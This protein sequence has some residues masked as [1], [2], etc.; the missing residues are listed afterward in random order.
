MI[1]KPT[2]IITSLGRT[3][4]LFFAT[5]FRQ[6]LPDSTSLHEPDYFN[7]GQYR[8]LREKTTEAIRQIRE[9]GFCN[10][11]IRKALGRWNL[12]AVSDARVC[13]R[14]TRSDAVDRIL[15]QRETFAS[16][17]RGSIYVE[18]SSALYGLID[19]LPDVF[20]EHRVIYLVR[21]GRDWIRSMMNFTAAVMYGKTRL[22]S[23]VSPDWPTAAE[24][25]DGRFAAKWSSMSV[26]EKL[27]WAWTRLN[28]YALD[29]VCENPHARVFRFEDVF[30]GD[31]RYDYLQELV[32]FA[33]SFPDVRLSRQGFNTCL[34][35]EVHGSSTGFPRWEDW[36]IDQ[37]R[38]YRATCGALMERL[39]YKLK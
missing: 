18:S 23:L 38:Q 36:S 27:C 11:T 12:R 6:L 20:S 5:L 30:K 39:G 3:G 35:Q 33:T 15:A 32:T 7:F 21:D 37:K 1:E 14:L 17:R 28:G 19:V 8:S 26:F 2:V 25:K 13:G 29:S 9:S 34:E 22:Q 31:D 24:L 10:L 16:S 4:T